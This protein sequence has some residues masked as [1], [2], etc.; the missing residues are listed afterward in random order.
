MFTDL[1]QSCSILGPQV[2]I[3]TGLVTEIRPLA[4][5]RLSSSRQNCSDTDNTRVKNLIQ[6]KTRQRFDKVKPKIGVHL[7]FV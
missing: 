2:T 4:E 6:E 7:K 5:T 1:A 3:I